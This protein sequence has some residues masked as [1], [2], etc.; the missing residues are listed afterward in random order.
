[1]M[2][3]IQVQLPSPNNLLMHMCIDP[4]SRV[5]LSDE[6][7]AERSQGGSRYRPVPP[8]G[9]GM[10]DERMAGPVLR[11]GRGKELAAAATATVAAAI[12]IAITAASAIVVTKQKQDDQ[13]Q[14]PGAAAVAAA[15]AEQIADTHSR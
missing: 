3:R 9:T 6:K 10:G 8:A 7:P 4:L 11:A 14:D 12:T 1:M 15:T 5:W 2:N 13:E